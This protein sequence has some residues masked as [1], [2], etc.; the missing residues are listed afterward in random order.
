MEN[1]AGSKSFR[2][3]I[4]LIGFLAL[5]GLLFQTGLFA[6]DDDS[7]KNLKLIHEKTFAVNPSENLKLRTD[8]G[9]VKVSSWDKNE[10]YVKVFGNSRAQ[11]DLEYSF[12]KVSDGVE[13]IVK[14]EGMNFFNLF[15]NYKLRYEIKVPA[16]FNS[17]ISTAGGDVKVTGLEGYV[18]SA[19]SGGDVSVANT[20][21]GLDLKT[22][23]G[24]VE[25]NETTGDADVST[26]GGDIKCKNH[27]GNVKASTSGGDVHL[28]VIDGRVQSSTSG[29]DVTLYYKGANKGVSLSSSG[30][31]IKAVLPENFAANAELSTSGGD[32]TCEITA[33][34]TK[35]VTSS[36]F[37]ADL[38]GGGENLRCTTSGGDIAVGKN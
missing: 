17:Y 4:F 21:G 13:I 31:D 6:Q 5:L 28:S 23:G 34:K 1:M 33:T 12:E 22:S 32:V 3:K 10:V 30:G 14:K 18:K 16:K 20:R 15:K 24:D 35:K 29:G 26:S 9:D 2:K 37:I 27:K 11:E 38:N 36:K 25:F 7:H 19:T 8:V